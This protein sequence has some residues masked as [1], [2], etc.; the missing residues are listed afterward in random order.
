LENLNIDKRVILMDLKEM[1]WKGIY[2]IYL[3]QD[4]DKWHVVVSKVAKLRVPCNTMKL[5]TS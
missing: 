3:A 2:W 4:K 1:G 5:L